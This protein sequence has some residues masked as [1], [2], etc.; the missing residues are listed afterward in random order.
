MS[1]PAKAV[2]TSRPKKRGRAIIEGGRGTAAR[3]LAVLGAMLQFAVG[4]KLTPTNPAKGA[5]L[6]KGEKKE[7]FLSEAEVAR[8][9]DTLAIMEREYRLSS[10]AATAVRLL[11]LTG[12]RKSEILT[13]RWRWVD[14]ERSCMRLHDRKTGAKVVPL[15]AA[16]ME[17]LNGLPRDPKSDFVLPASNG[18]G[19]LVGLQ[20]A[21]ERVRAKANLPGVRL[22][23]L[24]H[25]FASFAV[26][27]GNTL[28]MVSKVLGHRQ[29]R[30]TEGY[31]HL[32]NDP[33][34]A[35][36]DRTAA[37]IAAAMTGGGA[38][39]EVLPLRPRSNDAAR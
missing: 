21:W 14:F 24:G 38:S 32:A 8:L 26:A 35:V 11:L 36:A 28:F 33:L 34:R 2:R 12:C 20:N 9:A 5:R 30:T 27:D 13:L 23:D 17:L 25:S 18:G 3:S 37:R 6:F 4:R 39:A 31:A 7:W 10:T 1:P 19:H 29:S 22:H 15:A 16:A